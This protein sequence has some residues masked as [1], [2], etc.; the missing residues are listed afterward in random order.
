MLILDGRVSVNGKVADTLPVL[1]DPATDR[2]EVDGRPVRIERPIYLLMHKPR[3]VVCTNNDPS[4]RRRAVDLLSGVR[5]RVYPVGRLDEDSTGLLL[6]TNDGALAERIAHPRYGVPKTYRAE[7]SGR[8]E[9]E[10]LVKLREGV[11]LS[12]GRTAPADARI[13]HRGRDASVLEVTLRE[14]RNREV[15]RV[16][17]RL[18]HNVRR[19][20]R[21]AIGPL[22]LGP[23][24]AG[25]W[26]PLAPR[27]LAAL[28]RVMRAGPA[29][30]P[31]MRRPDKPRA[32]RERPAGERPAGA[33][34]VKESAVTVRT[35]R[36][37]GIVRRP[38]GVES[39]DGRA[40]GRRPGAATP[41]RR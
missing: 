27:E 19:L 39:G 34:R 9:G 35:A 12:D 22:Q 17:A 6:L 32:S 5:E 15:R 10:S 3:G 29:E 20:K 28:Q 2:I 7:V 37:G 40:R 41:R 33:R 1:V 4:G 25:A 24:P 16:L 30:W 13:I 31:P 21:I 8:V 23:L 36:S 18:G 26:R 11:W 14:G 38:R